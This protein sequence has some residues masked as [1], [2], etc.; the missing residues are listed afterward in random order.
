MLEFIKIQTY[1]KKYNPNLK[2]SLS[3][4]MFDNREFMVSWFVNNACNFSC[5]Y[6]GHYNFKPEPPKYN[7]RHIAKSF[8]VFGDCG[9]IIITGGEP[10]LYPHFVDLC[11]LLTEKHYISINTNLSQ[12]SVK[13]FAEHINPQRIIMINAGVH[14]DYRID[15]GIGIEGYLKKYNVLFEK[16]F[17]VVGSYVIHPSKINQDIDNIENLKKMGVEKISAKTFYGKYNNKNYPESY[18][19]QEI[20]K[21]CKYMQE[22]ID[23][24]EYLK[25]VSFRNFNCF[26][27][28]NFFSIEHNG[29]V[30]RCNTDRA[31]YGNIFKGTFI[32]S[33][34]AER[35]PHNSCICPYQGMI[36]SYK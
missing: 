36:Y 5:N 27:G 3:E 22:S 9:H 8:D 23:M 24:P 2:I 34:N 25:Y 26:A 16:G 12:A 33:K 31:F 14:Y 21:I 18:T 11:K 15:K 29:D 32:A 28:K 10:F 20:E 13:D 35:C 1:L 30:L 6:C 7:I 4:L 19:Q 17:N